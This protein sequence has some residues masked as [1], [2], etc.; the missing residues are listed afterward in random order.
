[1]GRA[2]SGISIIIAATLA[3]GCIL[4]RGLYYVDDS[5]AVED[6]TATEADGGRDARAPANDD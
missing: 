3:S 6:V 5:P 2:L 1:M 4:G